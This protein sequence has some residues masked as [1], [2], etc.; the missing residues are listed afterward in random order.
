MLGGHHIV[1]A[2]IGLAGDNSELGHS[3]LGIGIQQLGSVADDTVML[4]KEQIVV[5]NNKNK[6]RAQVITR[7][8][9][10][11]SVCLYVL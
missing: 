10:H 5:N 7:K 3:G 1:S 4:L 2:S 8:S 11:I 9:M 6:V